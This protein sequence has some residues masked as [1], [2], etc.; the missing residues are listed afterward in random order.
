MPETAR[1]TDRWIDRLSPR[2]FA[3]GAGLVACLVTLYFFCP[4]FYVW[5][6]LDLLADEQPRSEFFAAVA[7][8]PEINRAIIVLAQLKNPEIKFESTSNEAVNWRPFFPR[9]GHTLG[10]SATTFL[11]LTFVGCW[12]AAALIAAVM[13]RQLGDRVQAFWATLLACASAWFFVSTSWLSY[14]DSWTVLGLV[15]VT[16]V[17]SRWA[18]AVACFLECWI[19]ERF[20]FALPTAL[21]LRTFVQVRDTTWLQTFTYDTATAAAAAAPY[22][23]ARL[24]A[25]FGGTDPKAAEQVAA[26]ASAA[27][28]PFVRYLEG[29][30]AGLRCNW[31]F[32]GVWAW[33]AAR[34]QPRWWSAMAIGGT[35]I[36][37]LVALRSDGD[38]HRSAGMFVVVALAGI[39]MLHRARPALCAKAIPVMALISLAL[40]ASHVITVFKIPIY[41]ATVE[42]DRSHTALPA[43]LTP[44]FY[45]DRGVRLWNEKKLDRALF[46]FDFALKI[47]PNYR[48]AIVYKSIVMVDM[49]RYKEALAVLDPALRDHPDW[50][51]AYYMRGR[52]REQ[53]ADPR[54]ALED[55]ERAVRQAPAE[56]EIRKQAERAAQRL[57]DSL[58]AR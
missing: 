55:Y 4:R 53:L 40:P 25:H 1:R 17:R 15:T 35:L 29:A 13:A 26:G 39:A 8:H 36:S 6:G 14:N 44:E 10:L 21:I 43:N 24:S 51:D 12:A 32:V 30:W 42:W 45:S 38:L 11:S 20:L 34:T 31:L 9:L 56:S 27:A 54:G 22:L 18:L 46:H 49:A 58:P 57:R 19:D 52:C 48:P 5:R 47:D 23:L 28:V 3:A 33:L 50:P 2:W 37:L 16:F 41:G 7:S